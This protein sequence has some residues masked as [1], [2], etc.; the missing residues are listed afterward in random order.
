MRQPSQYQYTYT[1]LFLIGWQKVRLAETLKK[2][3]IEE[4]G[5]QQRGSTDKFLAKKPSE[6]PQFTQRQKLDAVQNI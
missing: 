4:V 1:R 6:V 2:R 3:E 5:K